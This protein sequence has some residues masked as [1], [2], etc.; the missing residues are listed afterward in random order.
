MFK[1]IT[2]LCILNL[3]N[4]CRDW[5]L[6]SVILTCAPCPNARSTE[7]SGLSSVQC[8][9]TLLLNVSGIC[10]NP[11]MSMHWKPEKLDFSHGVLTLTLQARKQNS[12]CEVMWS[13]C[14]VLVDTPL[15]AFLLS[16]N[17]HHAPAT[18][19]QQKG[20]N[21]RCQIWDGAPRWERERVDGGSQSKCDLCGFWLMGA[22]GVMGFGQGKN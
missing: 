16:Y 11:V 18:S 17:S 13:C 7:V 20:Q 14:L 21:G 15:S 1:Y 2:L 10:S 4:S 6:L 19:S 5:V 12:C 9:Q 22:E 8:I 3:Y